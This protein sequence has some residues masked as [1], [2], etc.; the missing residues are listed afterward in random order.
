MILN[1]I[2]LKISQVYFC[3]IFF[4]KCNWMTY[5]LNLDPAWHAWFSSEHIENA[6]HRM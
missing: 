6:S 3:P 1:Q 4:K 2:I 5:F